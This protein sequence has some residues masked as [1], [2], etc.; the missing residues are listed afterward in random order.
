MDVINSL[1]RPSEVSALIQLKLGGFTNGPKLNAKEKLSSLQ[2]C[3]AVL[4]KVSRSFAIVIRQLPDEL[5]DVVCIFYLVLRGLD[6]VEDDMDVPY[7]EKVVLLRQ[8]H[9]LIYKE[10]WNLPGVGDTPDYKM[11]MTYFDNVISEFLKLEKRY[12]D[13]IANITKQMGEGMA[14][15]VGKTPSNVNEYNLYCH[16]VA[17]LVGH[18]LT[19]L[20]VESGLE[21]SSLASTEGMRIADSMGM[22]LQKTNI[23]RD[24]LEDLEQGRT[25]WPKEIWGQYAN[26]LSDFRDQPTAPSSL[27][28]LNHMIFDAVRHM[29]D[30]IKYMQM[31]RNTKIFRFCAIPQIMAMATLSKCY[32]NHKVFEENVKIRKGLGALIMVDTKNMSSVLHRF[33]EFGA[34]MVEQIRKND[35]INDPNGKQTQECLST[36]FQM[37]N[38]K[39]MSKSSLQ[40]ATIIVWFIIIIGGVYMLYPKADELGS[41]TIQGFI[42]VFD[43]IVLFFK[44]LLH[45]ALSPF[46]SSSSSSP[47]SLSS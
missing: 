25:W 30:C 32:N 18:G 41:Q 37:A 4:N 44:T 5:R 7:E 33:N 14:D 36:V 27:A 43:L 10:G 16:Y 31:L 13:V 2:W 34:E 12:Q 26:Q 24:Y 42:Y 45:V 28:C 23:I 39:S 38:V 6:S 9:T 8:F 35:P 19:R 46:S 21:D 29:E 47:S 1:F 20:F 17:G 40:Y 15:F 11:L 22:F 3:Y